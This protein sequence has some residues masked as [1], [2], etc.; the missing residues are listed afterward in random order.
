ME[1]LFQ[2]LKKCQGLHMKIKSNFPQLLNCTAQTNLK[3]NK[4][5]EHFLLNLLGK[6]RNLNLF[7][8][9]KSPDQKISFTPLEPFNHY[10]LKSSE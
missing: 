5:Q 1:I 10:E 9:Y 7:Y 3:K 2:Q 4:H 6:N 8:F